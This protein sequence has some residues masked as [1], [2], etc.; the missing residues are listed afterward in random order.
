VAVLLAF[1]GEHLTSAD[2]VEEYG[3]DQ[4]VNLIDQCNTGI[5]A[6]GASIHTVASLLVN[7][8]DGVVPQTRAEL[9]KLKVDATVSD[10][11]LLDVF[12][13]PQ[14]VVGL[15]ARKILVAL[16]MVDWEET[17]ATL[18]SDVKMVDVKAGNV[19]KSLQTWLPLGEKAGFHDLMESLGAI[20][21]DKSC[22]VWGKVRRTI[23]GNFNAKDKKSL[24]GDGFD[25]FCNLWL[26]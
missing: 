23:N 12:G 14:L 21:S 4:L 10:L 26:H 24:I 15:H 20:V 2:A 22:G 16:D 5:K 6:V 18:K 25:H 8:H 13:A 17:G 9:L 19:K 11:L 7:G 1:V 3:E